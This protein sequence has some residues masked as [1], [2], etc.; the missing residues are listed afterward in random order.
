MRDIVLC[1]KYGDRW[2]CYT[3]KGL[4]VSW[5]WHCEGFTWCYCDKD[6]QGF[7]AIVTNNG[8]VSAYTWEYV[9]KPDVDP[10]T[11]AKRLAWLEAIS[12]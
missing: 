12:S 9:G 6:H 3:C 8:N 11:A 1:D 7:L 10:E 4:F 5:I 2:Q